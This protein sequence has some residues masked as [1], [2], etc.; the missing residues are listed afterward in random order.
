MPFLYPTGPLQTGLHK[1]QEVQKGTA[2]KLS[3]I[4]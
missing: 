2:A 1:G 4:F 3:L